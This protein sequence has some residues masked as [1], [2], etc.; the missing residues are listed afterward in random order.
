M[1]GHGALSIALLNPERYSSVSAFSPICNPI[2]SP[3][4]KKAFS[5]YLGEDKTTWRHYD[6]SE[7]MRR[8]TRFMPAKVDQGGSDDFMKEQLKPEM[9]TAAAKISG[10]PLELHVH[11]GYDH[12]YYFIASFIE[13]HLRFH[14]AHLNK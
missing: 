9:L 14:A 4:G 1:G 7:L 13:Q 12:S 5:A 10:Y 11:K 6:A 8:A 2:N 3:W